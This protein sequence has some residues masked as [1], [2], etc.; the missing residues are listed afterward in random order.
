MAFEKDLN[1]DATELRLGQPGTS[2]E[3][4]EKITSPT[5]RSN[6]RALPDMNEESMSSDHNSIVAAAAKNG[7]KETAPPT[8]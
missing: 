8:K 1:L 4:A 7:D 3:S 6:K 5:L 2:E